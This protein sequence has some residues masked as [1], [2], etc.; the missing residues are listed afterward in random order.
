MRN[1]S[2]IKSKRGAL[3]DAKPVYESFMFKLLT[4]TLLGIL[5][6]VMILS[7]I[8]CTVK[9]PEAPSWDTQLVIPLVNRTYTMEELMSKIDD[10]GLQVDSMGGFSFSFEQELDTVTLDAAALT[11]T[12][13]LYSM[14]DSLNNI[15][16]DIGEFDSINITLKSLA[17]L[18][19]SLP[20]DSLTLPPISFN[21]PRALPSNT[22]YSQLTVSSG[23]IRAIIRNDLGTSID[24]IAVDIE[25]RDPYRFITSKT[26]NTPILTSQTDTFLVPLDSLSLTNK[27]KIVTYVFGPGGFIDSISTRDMSITTGFSDPFEVS[28]A[29]AKIPGFTRS[30]S[31]LVPLA[32]NDKIDTAVLSAGYLQINIGNQTNLSASLVITIPDIIL[33]GSPIVINRT[34]PPLQATAVGIDLTGYM[35]VPSDGTVPQQ[36]SIDVEITV[37]SSAPAM[38]TISS[39]DNFLVAASLT[40]LAFSSVKGVIASQSADFSVGQQELDVPTGFDSLLFSNIALTLE[41]DNHVN[42][43]GSLAVLLTNNFGDTLGFYG[44]IAPND[45]TIITKSDASVAQFLSPLPSLI[46]FAGSASF[47]DGVTVGTITPDDYVSTT[48]KIFA[49]LEVVLV[50]TE[51]ETDIEKTAINQA[52]I[53]IITDHL[54][55]AKFVYNIT[56]HL[57]IGAGITVF[58]SSDSATLFSN[59]ELRIE[60]LSIPAA[61]F[62]LNGIVIADT[63]SGD[64][65]ISLDSADI[66][67]LKTDTLYIGQEVLLQGSGGQTIKLTS[68]DFISVQGRIEIEYRVGN[69]F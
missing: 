35:I 27:L 14:S 20:G 5:V 40:G 50:E 53:D 10:E 56:S 13:L 22:T 23:S 31:E 37:D 69:N 58:I 2:R 3:D 11:T 47:G 7:L 68:N 28:S 43:P 66:Q 12:D 42:L 45:L 55:E 30:F 49:P 46:D 33:A 62:D 1:N 48:V 38:A 32:E 65:I 8:Q 54:I 21:S 60:A 57:P 9:K 44:Y 26:F 67:I 41:I 36:I 59:P 64:Q 18:A 29:T 6:A 24:S 51:I 15:N 4:K 63:S 19:V 52:D 61:P 39:G 17:G 16:I 34:V 25:E